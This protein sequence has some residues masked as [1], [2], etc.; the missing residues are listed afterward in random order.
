MANRD[1]DRQLE[2]IDGETS[3]EEATAPE[4][5]PVYQVF[6]NSKIPVSPKMGAFWERRMKEGVKY[7]ENTHA[8]DR[9]DE[10][11][12]YYQNDQGGKSSKRRKLSQVSTGRDS[13]AALDYGTENI[14]FGNVSSL[15]PAIYAKNP[16][17]EITSNKE[18][19]DEKQLDMYEK[20]V[21]VLFDRKVQP[22]LNLKNKMRRA[23]IMAMLTNLSYIELSYV[24]KEDSSQAVVDEVMKLSE[25][26]QA[27]KDTKE[28]ARIEGK[29]LA[30]DER[31]NML[32]ASGPRMRVRAPWEVIVDDMAEEPDLS[33]AT[34]AIVCDYI[35]TEF[36]RAMYGTMDS[37][38][39]WKPIYAPSHVVSAA[40]RD[41]SGH[42]DEIN[43]F[44][45]LG[46]GEEDYKKYGYKNESDY[47][48]ACRTKV[49]YVWDKT[50]RRVLLFN[51]KDWSMPIWVWD[52]PYKLSRFFPFFALSFYT[53]PVERYA[54]S[55]VMYYL[56]Q[57]DEIN[58][59]N[60][61]RSRMRHWVMSKVFV[62]TTVMQDATAV[63]KFLSN[64][65]A[66]TVFGVKLPEGVKISDAIG[67]LP[68][69]ST[70][71]EQLFDTG[72]IL[73]SIN[74]LSS[75][76][77]VLQNEQFKT[78]T[79]NKAIESYES[80][81]QTRLDE[82]IDAIEDILGDIGQA[83]LE[84]CVQFMS[85]DDVAALIGQQA[86]AAAGGWQPELTPEQFNETYN[87]AIVGGST[88]KPTSK[89]K[90]EQAVQLGQTVGQFATAVPTVIPVIMR[91]FERAFKED[92]VITDEDW[93]AI[94]QALVQAVTQQPAPSANG[95]GRPPEGGQAPQQGGQP[96]ADQ[97]VAGVQAVAGIIDRLDPQKKA[98]VGAAIA[99]GVSLKDVVAQLVQ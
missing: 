86:I 72:P 17:I 6:P 33:D 38:G 27:A 89:V 97:I 54:R 23:T 76:T 26:L 57:Q 49:W 65:T 81:T 21:N 10:V 79:T 96:S 45:L 82:K 67:T 70:Q 22:G 24:K 28:I 25:E 62:N 77:P 71:F 42:D 69:P 41:I 36:L 3:M 64:D 88:L 44:A 4:Y 15:V 74:R 46:D 29:L 87:F 43:H 9:W 1:I 52:D 80:S 7:L 50:T 32:S 84:M 92:F 60:N 73:Q 19:S 11:I 99:K 40:D 94:N 68:A 13:E 2:A 30:L 16:D 58:K 78:N 56:D 48:D 12:R 35:R 90:K 85:S 8:K 83:L 93:A 31:I 61:E 34:Y 51:D 66:D 75:V 39:N 18:G 37:D 98:A 55:E 53:D 95:G 59:I 5:T 20:L 63:K 91:M 14:V 47:R